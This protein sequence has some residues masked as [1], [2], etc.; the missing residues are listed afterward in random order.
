MTGEAQHTPDTPLKRGNPG[1]I[2]N[3]VPVFQHP[4][5]SSNIAE[6]LRAVINDQYS[7]IPQIPC[8]SVSSRPRRPSRRNHKHKETMTGGE[9][10]VKSK[11]LEIP[12][13]LNH[14]NYMCELTESGGRYFTYVKT[15]ET[16]DH[17]IAGLIDTGSQVTI[18][19]QEQFNEEVKSMST[20]PRLRS[21]DCSLIG[22]GGEPLQVM[23]TAWLKLK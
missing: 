4:S 20:K 18:L 7:E 5:K 14:A 23:G 10:R 12:Q 2:V 21:F 17:H 13:I 6:P 22:V 19:S 3:Y 15:H 1:G 8:A 9:I 16:S 11:L